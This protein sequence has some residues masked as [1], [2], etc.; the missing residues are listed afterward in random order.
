M[1][2][3]RVISLI[4]AI[5]L[6]ASAAAQTVLSG[7]ILSTAD[8]PIPF[9]NVALYNLGD[10]VPAAGCIADFDGAY[11]I[12]AQAN[13]YR[14]QISYVGYQTITDT[15]DFHADATRNFVLEEQTTDLAE[16]AVHAQSVVMSTE[17]NT[18]FITPNDA[19]NQQS[20]L[21]LLNIIPKISV[22]MLS[23]TVKGIGGKSVKLLLNGVDVNSVEL[24]SLPPDKIAKIER[25]DIPPARY[26]DYEIVLNVITKETEDGFMANIDLN[27]AFT[28]GFA[29]PQIMLQYN[30][31]Q[32]NRLTVDYYLGYRNY[33]HQ[34]GGYSYTYEIDK[35]LYQEIAEDDRKFGYEQHVPNITYVRQDSVNMFQVKFSPTYT[36]MHADADSARRSMEYYVGNDA[37]S[38]S[39][40]I[41]RRNR[42]F[43]PSLDI[44]YS[45]KIND[46]NEIAIDIT[47]T[48]FSTKNRLNDQL[49]DAQGNLFMN[50]IVSEENTKNSLIGELYFSHN[51]ENQT[52]KGGYILNT[53]K[54]QS[55]A[56]NTLG[57]WDD[58]TTSFTSNYV[59]GELIGNINK[60]GYNLTLGVTN[61]K[62]KT[63]DTESDAWIFMPRI[64][65]NYSFTENSK[66]TLQFLHKNS[67]PSISQ[68]RNSQSYV[69]NNIIYT[70]NPDLKHSLL[71]RVRLGYEQTIANFVGLSVEGFYSK[72]KDAIVGLYTEQNGT[73]YQ[74]PQN[75][76]SFDRYG[77][78]YSLEAT[79]PFGEQ[80][81]LSLQYMG[82]IEYE[83]LRTADI[84]Y[85]HSYTPFWLYAQLAAG[86]FMA[87]Y[88]YNYESRRLSGLTSNADE[89]GSQM[90][91]AW[92]PNQKFCLYAKGLF[93]GS[94][95]CKY[96]TRTVVD[97]SLVHV[98]SRTRI[99]DNGNMIVIGMQFKFTAGKLYEQRNKKINNSDND[100]GT[101]FQ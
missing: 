34:K 8:Q 72:N 2:Q 92:E 93:V 9:A 18:Y 42:D 58:V 90:A 27:S 75:I 57:V 98:D 17:K 81:A 68:L 13:S 22:D 40:L 70:G 4:V 66:L 55:D 39:G 71:S 91:L 86:K 48:H 21:N 11:K 37:L 85:T 97:E 65:A 32:K 95:A 25:Y 56:V 12:S 59:Y 33:K 28:T 69:T 44:Y 45:R 1:T 3:Q 74:Q 61:R 53:N 54:Q 14:I 23:N 15:I 29:D 76:K 43:T 62:S 100:A 73:I 63:V 88:G 16:V 41:Y 89:G 7:H 99:T 10:S 6:C 46:Q 67:E 101:F 5:V 20:A 78:D 83:R 64:V 52:L 26:A 77:A 19:K 35:I 96:H 94:S 80:V 30:W 31:R 49:S 50:N 84:D 24:K 60:F 47:T 87:I 82:S 79:I 36:H 51:F 38:L